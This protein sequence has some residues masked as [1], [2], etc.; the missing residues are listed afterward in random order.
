[1]KYL[2]AY[3]YICMKYFW[4]KQNWAM[5]NVTT[6]WEHD[7]VAMLDNGIDVALTSQQ[8]CVPSWYIQLRNCEHFFFSHF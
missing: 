1:M 7:V 6:H 3:G 2:S 8:R 5:S 4:M